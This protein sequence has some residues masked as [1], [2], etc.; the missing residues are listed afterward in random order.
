MPVERDEAVAEASNPGSEVMDLRQQ[1]SKGPPTETGGLPTRLTIMF[2]PFVAASAVVVAWQ[3]SAPLA[4]PSDV[5]TVLRSFGYK[6]DAFSSVVGTVTA[7]LGNETTNVQ[8][9]VGFDPGNKPRTITFFTYYRTPKAISI[10]AIDDWKGRAAC[11]VDVQLYLNRT[12]CATSIVRMDRFP[13]P[14]ALHEAIDQKLSDFGVFHRLAENTM[15]CT[16]I[17]GFDPKADPS[18][19]SDARVVDYLSFSDL[20]MLAKNWGW[21]FKGPYGSAISSQW[22]YPLSVDGETIVV[23]GMPGSLTALKFEPYRT[24]AS[25]GAGM[26]R[27]PPTGGFDPVGGKTLG[28]LKREILKYSA[29]L[30]R[31]ESRHPG[32]R[33]DAHTAAKDHPLD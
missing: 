9:T 4:P 24:S 12:L 20:M 15:G 6:V 19:L 30:K 16:P 11:Q 29:E 13:N 10:Q 33:Q 31:L 1:K 8:F 2:I 32:E 27:H 28:E 21:E 22:S 7:S 14:S 26:K 25:T 5:P 23:S 17:D 18:D 3:K